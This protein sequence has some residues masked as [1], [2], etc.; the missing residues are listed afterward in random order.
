MARVFLSHSSRDGEAASRMQRW[1]L[2][3][4]FE[5]PFLDFDK[6]SGIPPG[7]NWEQVL[8]R[9][10]TTS[11]AVLLL[12]SAQWQASKWCFAEFTQARALGKPVLPVIVGPL[13]DDVE[14]VAADVQTVDLRSNTADNLDRLRHQL[15]KIALTSQ[16]GLPWD[17]RRPPYPGLAALEP[18]DAALYFGREPEI[19]Q[20]VERLTARRSLG[21][22]SLLVVLGAS[23]S[24]KSSLLRAGVVPRLRHSGHQWVV[25]PPLRPQRRPL[26][27]LAL[28]L[29]DVFG[30]RLSWRD[31]SNQMRDAL[32]S[33]TQHAWLTRLANDLREA[34]AASEASILLAIDQAEELFHQSEAEER[35]GFLHLLNAALSEGMP[36]LAVMALRSDALATLQSEERL[37]PRIDQLSLA[38]LPVERLEEVILG[39]ARVAGLRVEPGLVRQML[40]DAGSGDSLPL[41]AFTLR[42]LYDRAAPDHHLTASAYE[43]LGDPKQGL[44]PLDNAV[45]SA[46][47][48]ALAELRPDAAQLEAVRE[49]FVPALVQVNE[50]GE[51]ARR[52]AQWHDLPAPAQPLLSA[53]VSARVLTLREERGER[54]LEVAHE[55]LLRKWPLLRGWLDE[56]RQFL[57]DVR[58][59][60]HAQK[61]WSEAIAPADAMEAEQREGLGEG[62]LLTGIKLSRAR[63]WLKE[64]P[65]DLPEELRPFLAASIAR[66]D[67]DLLRAKLRRQRVL[68]VLST[69]TGLALATTAAALWQLHQAQQAQREEFRS[70]AK[71]LMATHPVQAA[72]NALAGMEGMD[73]RMGPMEHQDHQLIGT[74]GLAL[75]RISEV[76]SVPLRLP[77]PSA[78]LALPDGSLIAASATGELR[79][80]RPREREWSAL[81]TRHPGIRALA[82]SG[83][84][85][86]LSASYDGTLRRWRG[87]QPLGPAVDGGQRSLISL[88]SLPGGLAVTGALDGSLRWWLRGHPLDDSKKTRLGAIWA[89]QPLDDGSVLVGGDSGLVQRWR[90]SGPVAEAIASGQGSVRRLA[91]LSDGTWVSG[92]EDGTVRRWRGGVPSETLGPR[93]FG[94]IAALAP[95]SDGG[96]AW[97]VDTGGLVLWN[98]R[99]SPGGVLVRSNSPVQS[100]QSVPGP[101][102]MGLSLEGSVIRW[103]W[104]RLP[105]WF[106]DTGQVSIHAL[107]AQNDGQLVT[108]GWD[109]TL[110]FWRAGRE[111]SSPIRTQQGPIR[112]LQQ[113][114]SGALLVGGLDANLQ[115]WRDGRPVG[116]K[117]PTAQVGVRSLLVLKN[118]DL[119]SGGYNGEIRRW[120][121]TRQIGPTVRNGSVPV[122]SLAELS[123]GELLAGDAQGQIRRLRWPHWQG[124][125]LQTGQRV[126]LS[127]LPLGE[128]SWLTAGRDGTLRTWRNGKPYGLTLNVAE[129][130]ASWR[131]ERPP[132]GELVMSSGSDSYLRFLVAPGMAI[133]EACHQLKELPKLQAPQTPAELAAARVCATAGVRTKP[134]RD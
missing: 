1:L 61:E 99:T 66:E 117:I 132:S 88:A 96:L 19:R 73:I 122:T 92:G 107:L 125:A 13:A 60:R 47:E 54:T 10:L 95:M 16:G 49:A 84:G 83:A 20:V 123:G 119:L 35:Q 130:G 63:A 111:V 34:A 18:E 37:E 121:K 42:E 97:S 9:E 29:S 36:Y 24:G 103:R 124:G 79:Q 89:L 71:G 21:G 74:L 100:L 131:V 69:L 55:A 90:A 68:A 65:R 106:R 43:A 3:Q 53:L 114:H 56:A 52:P 76:S 105:S 78:L 59:L 77:E 57:L 72:L 110:R 38:P 67:R 22:S 40:R 25:P 33:G 86:W 4:G 26:D 113:L 85:E 5:A 39:P 70:L 14:L 7:A 120:R 134:P 58:D 126:I 94:S 82:R 104:P 93:V 98:P 128:Q 46:A 27:S 112:I 116:R 12:L 101:S 109:S 2:N 102:V 81:A 91:L 23:G 44:S 41:L 133:Q 15:A 31:L 75:A 50:A 32:R 11:Q 48:R 129:E 64:R 17:G 127:I 115:E 28:A 8:Y 51:Y 118:G 62:A 80:S 45:R 6:H 87:R 30:D 108:G